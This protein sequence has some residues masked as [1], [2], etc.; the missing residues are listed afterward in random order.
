MITG[1][2]EGRGIST[3]TLYE[4]LLG[5]RDDAGVQMGDLRHREKKRNLRDLLGC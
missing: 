4:M 5:L 2:E 3:C 1:K